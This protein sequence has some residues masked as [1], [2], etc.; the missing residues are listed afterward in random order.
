MKIFEARLRELGITAPEAFKR[1]IAELLHGA[2]KTQ[3]Q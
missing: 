3:D 2:D 1:R